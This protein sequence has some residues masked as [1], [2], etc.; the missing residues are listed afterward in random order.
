MII[1]VDV[2]TISIVIAATSVVIGVINSILSSRRSEKTEQLALETR[3]AQLFMQI[4]N[5]WT[6]QDLS[7]SYSNIRYFYKYEDLDDHF[8]KVFGDL[9]LMT[10]FHSIMS[11]FEGLGMLVKKGLID[12]DLVHDLLSGRLIW[13][14]D[15][16][17]IPTVERA[18]QQLDDPTQFDSVEYLYNEMKK[19]EQQQTTSSN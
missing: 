5:R 9:E 13:L 12:I 6:Q 7:K 17:G 18:R 11:F 2:Q 3:Q 1:L 10:Q 16:F 19:R 14:W 15:T 8:K 4:Y